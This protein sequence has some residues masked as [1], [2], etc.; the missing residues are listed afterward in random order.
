MG[1]DTKMRGVLFDFLFTLLWKQLS[2]PTVKIEGD[3]VG[4]V[5]FFRVP[6]V[7]GSGSGSFG[8]MNRACARFM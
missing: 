1:F 6:P 8:I 7:K 4:P 3:R 2:R 5:I